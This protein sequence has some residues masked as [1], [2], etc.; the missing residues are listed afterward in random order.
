M[1]YCPTCV[2]DLKEKLRQS[3]MMNL[4]L[5]Q[6]YWTALNNN[7]SYE[8]EKSK[9]LTENLSLLE[10]EKEKLVSELKVLKNNQVKDSFSIVL[11]STE[12]ILSL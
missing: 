9:L 8:R 6:D 1:W 7:L 4:K 3:H 5:Q 2:Q 11:Q 12:T 10:L